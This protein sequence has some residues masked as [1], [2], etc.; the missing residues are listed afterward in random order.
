MRFIKVIDIKLR[1]LVL[2]V[3]NVIAPLVSK[4]GITS[5]KINGHTLSERIFSLFTKIL[6][7]RIPEPLVVN[8]MIMYQGVSG[9]L[10]P[11]W[12]YAF[13]YEPETGL[14]F[15]QII[16]PG[17]TVVDIGANIGYYTLLA[18]KLLDDN[19]KVYAFE[20]DPENYVLLKKNILLNKLEKLVEPLNLAVSNAEKKDSFFIGRST[21]SSLF[22]VPDS[23][24]ETVSV[25]LIPLDK[26]FRERNWPEVNFIKIDVEGAERFVLE[27]MAGLAER[28]IS[29]KLVIELNPSYLESAGI[30]PQQLLVVLAGM[31]F[32]KIRLLSGQMKFY[33]IPADIDYLSKIARELLF[34]NIFCEKE[35]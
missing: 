10:T 5:V 16:K 21:G 23:T 4:T 35:D 3:F 20:P 8:G 34:V 22:K 17:M 26:F 29:L 27:G 24:E 7:C 14:I 6:H 33:K 15:K 9:K 31:G 13:D 28:N 12:V 1:R 18:A 32:K 2:D 11:R 19:G 30:S 25:G